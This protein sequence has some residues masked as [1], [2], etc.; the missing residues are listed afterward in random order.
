V[1]RIQRFYVWIFDFG[2]EFF[3][4]DAFL[5]VFITRLMIVIS[6]RTMRAM[7]FCRTVSLEMPETKTIITSYN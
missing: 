3:T 2:V 5:V 4:I 6:A 7:T 1:V